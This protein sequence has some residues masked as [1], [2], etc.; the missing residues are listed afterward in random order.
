MT[1]TKKCLEKFGTTRTLPRAGHPARLSNRGRR[2]VVREVTKNLMVTL[3]EFQRSCVEMGETSRR[4][5]ITQYSTDL[6]FMA[7]WPDGSL[8]SI[9]DNR[10]PAWSFG[11]GEKQYSLV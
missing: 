9:K 2:A 5:T 1:A 8:F 7:E 11:Y 4:T 6:G 3:A 10:K